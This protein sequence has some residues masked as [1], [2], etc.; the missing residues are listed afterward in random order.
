MTNKHSSHS[1]VALLKKHGIRIDPTRPAQHSRRTAEAVTEQ[2]PVV[3]VD[4]L[5]LVVEL[6][7]LGADA[8]VVFGEDPNDDCTSCQQIGAVAD[9]RVYD[10][11]A[12]DEMCRACAPAAVRAATTDAVVVEVLPQ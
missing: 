11:P 10:G 8:R 6:E 5:E 9:V 1:A 7:T 12:Y 4:V 2:F 3:S